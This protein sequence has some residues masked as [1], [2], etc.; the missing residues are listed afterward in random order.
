MNSYT[1]ISSK[2]IKQNSHSFSLVTIVIHDLN[3]YDNVLDL[4]FTSNLEMIQRLRTL[5]GPINLEKITCDLLDKDQ[6]KSSGLMDAISSTDILTAN[7]LLNEILTASKTAFVHLITTIVASLKPGALFLIVDPASDFSKVTL[8]KS[9]QSA[10]TT[11]N[12]NQNTTNNANQNA[13]NT[14]NNTNESDSN[15]KPSSTIML[16]QLLDAIKSF[17]KI[18]SLDSCW[19]RFP[20]ELQKQYPI[21]LHNMRY[22]MR[23]YRK[24]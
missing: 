18:S 19:Y 21:K 7:F 24:V 11:N 5:N 22:F 16:F 6:I 4:L 20:P 13:T 10:N 23:I 1:S 12:A 9:S 14:N 2:A 15:S 3:L 8:C 17:E